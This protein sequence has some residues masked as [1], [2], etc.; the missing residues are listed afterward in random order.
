MS[1]KNCS[2]HA[3]NYEITLQFP[4]ASQAAFFLSDLENWVNWKNTQ[5]IPVVNP[6]KEGDRRGQHTRALHI[7]AR[8]YQALHPLIPYHECMRLCSQTI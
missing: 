2:C 3:N 1:C 6:N 5:A 4:R 8:E 7:K